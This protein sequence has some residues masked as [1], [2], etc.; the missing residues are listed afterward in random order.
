VPPPCSRGACGSRCIFHSHY[1][2]PTAPPPTFFTT[3]T[4]APSVASNKALSKSICR[5]FHAALTTDNLPRF[6][7]LATS[8]P[9]AL[10]GAFY[11]PNTPTTL[12]YA[13]ACNATSIAQKILATA[14]PPC[15]DTPLFYA[16]A[17]GHPAMFATLLASGL[18]PTAVTHLGDTLMH[19]ACETDNVT[20]LQI[21]LA[22]SRTDAS[23]HAKNSHALTPLHVA[24]VHGSVACVALLLSTFPATA[25]ATTGPGVTALHLAALCLKS[26][27]IA[28]LL[29]TAAPSLATHQSNSHLATPLHLATTT[30]NTPLLGL[31]LRNG[32]NANAKDTAGLTI[33][34]LAAQLDFQVG[35]MVAVQGGADATVRDDRGRTATSVCVQSDN[36]DFTSY[37]MAVAP[38]TSE[39]AMEAAIR[40]SA[41]NCL[42]VIIRAGSDGVATRK[43]KIA[44]D[45]VMAESYF[46]GKLDT[47]RA[48]SVVKCLEK[49]TGGLSPASQDLMTDG[50]LAGARAVCGGKV[51]EKHS[52]IALTILGF[53][54]RGWFGTD[55]EV[56]FEAWKLDGGFARQ[57]RKSVGVVTVGSGSSSS[58]LT[59]SSCGEE[60]S[61]NEGEFEFDA[62]MPVKKMKAKRE[63]GEAKGKVWTVPVSVVIE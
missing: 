24:V 52:K 12:S 54:G 47:D 42:P 2:L 41:V 48:T 11:G 57:K 5:Q 63:G 60:G 46:D 49:A 16:V 19:V 15:D 1:H 59:G 10:T 32:G 27:A 26:T 3:I 30:L 37:L 40:C 29:L 13:A 50:D 14:Q 23:V 28:Q 18:S 44:A 33:L 61:E 22:A 20:A 6:V 45:K 21:L 34:H 25:T 53:C 8:Y 17:A 58:S 38:S 31:L 7:E 36:A 62:P 35:A 39:G 55:E 51:F 4:G 56:G 43:Q 9:K